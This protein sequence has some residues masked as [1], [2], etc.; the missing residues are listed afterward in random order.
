MHRNANVF[1]GLIESGTAVSIITTESWD[2]HWPLQ[3]AG[4][5]LLG[6]G[7]ITQVKHSTRWVDCTGPGGPRVKL[8]QYLANIAVNLLFMQ[9]KS[10]HLLSFP[11]EGFCYC[12]L[13]QQ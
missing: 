2:P 7:T 11:A 12:S 1:V 4:V 8:R 6:N 9:M 3:E 13:F 10:G 5:R